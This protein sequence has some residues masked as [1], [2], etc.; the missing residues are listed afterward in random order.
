VEA[1][2]L[3]HDV[4]KLDAVKPEVNG[5]VHGEGSAE[6]L[7]RH[8]YP[9]LGPA[10][11]GHPVTRL[12]DAAWFTRWI[13][14]ASPEA[15]IVSYADKRAGQ[16]LESMAERF[17]SW[18]RRYPPAERAERARGTW[19][20]Q[21]MEDVHLRAA[22]IERRTCELASVAPGDVRRL[23][24]TGRAIAA[25]RGASAVATQRPAVDAG[26]R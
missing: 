18:Q 1:A 16:R 19:D 26:T 13:A 5:L 7:A 4:D 17:A 2:A 6:W 24:W 3:L 12:A 23:E 10:I 9:E 21:T 8:G 15:L 20:A 11:I 14:S 25:V 22:K